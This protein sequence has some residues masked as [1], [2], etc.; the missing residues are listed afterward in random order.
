MRL[1]IKLIRIL[2]QFKVQIEPFK[3]VG[4]FG[5]KVNKKKSSP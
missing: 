5:R 4:Y 3:G 2:S 1:K